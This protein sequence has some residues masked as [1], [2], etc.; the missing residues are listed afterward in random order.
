[1]SSAE[2]QTAVVHNKNGVK[3]TFDFQLDGAGFLINAVVSSTLATPLNQ[4]RVA[5]SVPKDL[6]VVPEVPSGTVLQQGTAG[7]VTQTFRVQ[8]GSKS[9]VS[10]APTVDH[11]FYCLA[12]TNVYM[13]AEEGRSAADAGGAYV[14]GSRRGE[15]ERALPCL[16]RATEN[17]RCVLEDV[18]RAAAFAG[19]RTPQGLC[20]RRRALVGR[21]VLIQNLKVDVSRHSGLL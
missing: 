7:T 9:M 1:M 20:V 4:F 15:E 10:G 12:L 8:S 3:V 5:L 19:R 13:C 6:V 17:C 11:L 18:V 14:G 2:M 16:Q 21:T